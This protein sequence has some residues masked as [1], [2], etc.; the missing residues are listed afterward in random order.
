V[1]L[2]QLIR[3]G[4]QLRFSLVDEEGR[5]KTSRV[6]F[7]LPFSVGGKPVSFEKRGSVV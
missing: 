7:Y 3:V 6:F 2:F 4:N 1:N 5:K